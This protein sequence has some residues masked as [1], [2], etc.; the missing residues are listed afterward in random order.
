MQ[1][2]NSLLT[3]T[4]AGSS[5]NGKHDRTGSGQDFAATLARAQEENAA[6]GPATIQTQE[7]KVAKAEAAREALWAEFHAYMEK[8]PAELMRERVLKEMGIS[9]EELASMPPEKRLAMEAEIAERVK[10]KLL[11]KQEKEGEETPALASTRQD[12]LNPMRSQL[13]AYPFLSGLQSSI[14]KI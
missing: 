13:P 11:G 10:E 4:T 9:E 5:R 7:D 2:D 12:L 6:R 8:T 3:P 1:I 14:Q